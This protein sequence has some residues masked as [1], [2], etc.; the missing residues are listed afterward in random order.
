MNEAADAAAAAIAAALPAG[1]GTI[2]TRVDVPVVDL[3]KLPAARTCFVYPNGFAQAGIASRGS[4]WM[5][6]KV[7]VLAVEKN[8]DAGDVPPAW[9]DARVAWV[10]AQVFGAAG[11]VNTVVLL[12]TL[13]PQ[14]R[15]VALPFDP[16]LLVTRN[17]FWSEVG[18]AYREIAVDG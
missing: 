18:L 9:T 12:G 17:V 16:E 3:D 11:D 4:F 6:Y 13:R 15:D 7:G 8:A 1:D 10:E 2:V 14:A 5:E